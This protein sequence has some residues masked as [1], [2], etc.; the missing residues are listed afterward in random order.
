MAAAAVVTVL[1]VQYWRRWFLL[2][3][4]YFGMRLSLGLLLGWFSP[5]GFVY[6]TFPV[7]MSA[8]AVLSFRFGKP[9]RVQIADRIALLLAAACLLAAVAGFLSPQPKAMALGFAAAGDLVLWLSQ[10]YPTW[11]RRKSRK[12]IEPSSALLTDR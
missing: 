10:M 1:T 2:I 11:K 9:A 8:M 6:V 7:L 5:K 4:G 3:A 12:R